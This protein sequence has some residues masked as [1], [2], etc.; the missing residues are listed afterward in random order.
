ML[1]A[2][3]RNQISLI[4]LTCL[5]FR[6]LA[7]LHKFEQGGEGR[8]YVS[9][10]RISPGKLQVVKH[11]NAEFVGIKN[12]SGGAAKVA[13]ALHFGMVE[14]SN[15]TTGERFSGESTN[16]RLK[17]AVRVTPIPVFAYREQ[18]CISMVFGATT[19]SPYAQ[20]APSFTEFATKL[21]LGECILF[22]VLHLTLMLY[23]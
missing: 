3:T 8:R 20:I 6:F 7:R 16:A 14:M 10:G 4:M 1:S 9:L 11:E 19:L 15:L 12:L 23:L 2:F 18:A 5:L 22:H 17:K 21:A 13:C